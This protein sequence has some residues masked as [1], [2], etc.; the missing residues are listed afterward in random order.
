MYT[1]VS[2]Y[3]CNVNTIYDMYIWD[4]T[5]A[6]FSGY[7]HKYPVSRVV[8]IPRETFI[9]L[10]NS[11]IIY[12][13]HCCTYWHFD[14]PHLPYITLMLHPLWQI[15]HGVYTHTIFRHPISRITQSV[16]SLSTTGANTVTRVSQDVYTSYSPHNPPLL[17]LL[18]QISSR[19]YIPRETFAQFL[20]DK[21]NLKC[22]NCI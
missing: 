16:H 22:V 19:V 17:H 3:A 5:F 8:Y 18:W 6:K 13:C 10:S 14:T 15:S 7:Y 1:R 2:Q 4:V 11:H 20:N 12:T 9:Q 21:V